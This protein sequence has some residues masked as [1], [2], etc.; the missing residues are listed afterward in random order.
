MIVAH[1]RGARRELEAVR[2]AHRGRHGRGARIE[3]VETWSHNPVLY[4]QL[5]YRPEWKT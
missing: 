5:N 3:D 4:P 1:R 2:A